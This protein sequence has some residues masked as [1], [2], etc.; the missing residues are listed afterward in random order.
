MSSTSGIET[1]L[2]PVTGLQAGLPQN[3]G[4]ISYRVGDFSLLYNFQIGSEVHPA[5]IMGRVGGVRFLGL[6]RPGPEADPLPRYGADFKI[7]V[8]FCML[9]SPST[10]LWLNALLS[11]RTTLA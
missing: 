10:S 6:K 8:D 3:Q 4:L 2:S 1:W 5:Y 7:Y 9:Y 11:A